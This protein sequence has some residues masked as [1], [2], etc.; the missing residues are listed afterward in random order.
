MAARGPERVTSQDRGGVIMPYDFFVNRK[1]QK[2]W[3]VTLSG[4]LAA[5]LNFTQKCKQTAVSQKLSKVKKFFF[6][7]F[8]IP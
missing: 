8:F 6:A 1:L 4:P 5:I 3:P 7:Y 2:T